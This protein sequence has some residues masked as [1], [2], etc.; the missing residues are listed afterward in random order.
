LPPGRPGSGAGWDEDS[1]QLSAISGQLSAAD[2]NLVDFNEALKCAKAKIW[3]QLHSQ[4][5]LGNEKMAGSV[6]PNTKPRSPM[7]RDKKTA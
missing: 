7:V 6:R 3:L 1:C 2:A 5:K 4:V